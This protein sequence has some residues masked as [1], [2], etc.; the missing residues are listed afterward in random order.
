MFALFDLYELGEGT[1]EEGVVT[2]QNKEQTKKTKT[3][4]LPNQ[5]VCQAED[6]RR[7]TQADW[8]W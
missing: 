4:N 7:L 5:L 6:R 2:A 8:Y 1:R 3:N